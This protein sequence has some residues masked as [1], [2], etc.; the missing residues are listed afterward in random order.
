MLASHFESEPVEVDSGVTKDLLTSYPLNDQGASAVP[1]I[2]T[3]Q[4][5]DGLPQA[6]AEIGVV[7]AVPKLQ[8]GY[9]G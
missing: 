3:S 1:G 9:R 7:C 6:E 8:V 4:G 5:A 2:C